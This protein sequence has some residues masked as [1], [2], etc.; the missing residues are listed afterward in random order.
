M[1][2]LNNKQITKV[3]EAE[4]EERDDIKAE[5]SKIEEQH[6]AAI[7]DMNVFIADKNEYEAKLSKTKNSNKRRDLQR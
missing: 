2:N 3:I 1:Q 4:K 5:I 7:N 6:K